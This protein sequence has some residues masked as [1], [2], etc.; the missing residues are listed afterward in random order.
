MLECKWACGCFLERQITSGNSRGG[1]SLLSEG[2]V[3][4]LQLLFECH[5]LNPG[6]HDG[7]MNGPVVELKGPSV[8]VTK[9]SC[10]ITLSQFYY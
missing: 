4:Y 6:S 8:I 3:S 5:I 9:L 10:S 7:P 1:K 2:C